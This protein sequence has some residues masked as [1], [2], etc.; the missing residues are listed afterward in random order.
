MTKKELYNILDEAISEAKTILQDNTPFRTG[1]MRNSWRIEK[2]KDKYSIYLD[3]NQAPYAV[4]TNEPWKN[5]NKEN[6]NENWIPYAFQLVI[7]ILQRK[8][9]GTMRKNNK[10]DGD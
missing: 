7:N 9:G 3:T 10:K 1:N 8:L 6:P 5:R 2:M 4:Y